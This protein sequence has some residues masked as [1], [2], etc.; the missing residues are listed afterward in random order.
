MYGLQSRMALILTVS[1]VLGVH[2]ARSAERHLADWRIANAFASDEWL[3]ESDEPRYSLVVRAGGEPIVEDETTLGVFKLSAGPL[4][5]DVALYDECL[6]RSDNSASE[7]SPS[8]LDHSDRMITVFVDPEQEVL[9]EEC[10]ELL[11]E[12]ETISL[13]DPVWVLLPPVEE[14]LCDG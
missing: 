14:P 6:L 3:A 8:E 1:T 12:P 5:F 10:Q 2:V 7:D 9:A 13:L 4:R 11:E